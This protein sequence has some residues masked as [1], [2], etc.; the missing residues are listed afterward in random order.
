MSL[1]DI[2]SAS[3]FMEINSSSGP[4]L[5][6]S[7]TTFLLRAIFF[8]ILN[9]IFFLFMFKKPIC[10]LSL[11]LFPLTCLSI[12]STFLFDLTETQGEI[13]YNLVIHIVFSLLS[14]GFLGLAAL[15]AILL[16]YQGHKL[17]NINE[18]IL[19]VFQYY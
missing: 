19:P 15:Q 11:V 18:S 14:Y 6:I 7:P 12:L 1:F 4:I 10:H 9:Y 3:W 5:M 2:F 17:R 8:N 16:K 13:D